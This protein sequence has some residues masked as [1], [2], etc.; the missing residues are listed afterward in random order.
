MRQVGLVFPPLCVL[1]AERAAVNI[2]SAALLAT[3]LGRTT[4]LPPLF[5]AASLVP[6][7]VGFCVLASPFSV[8]PPS[9]P[10]FR[11]PL[12]L[13]SMEQT[14]LLLDPESD[15]SD[16]EAA[17]RAQVRRAGAIDGGKQ[18]QCAGVG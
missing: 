6:T 8:T 9:A 15:E 17:E 2:I 5:A 4:G 7:L 14:Q 12:L 10:H 11:S 18:K 3:P 1:A 16:L 13:R